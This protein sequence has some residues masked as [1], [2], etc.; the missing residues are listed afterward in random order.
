MTC[1]FCDATP[2]HMVDP[3]DKGA[4]FAFIDRMRSKL[5]DLGLTDGANLHAGPGWASF[6]CAG[7]LP[8]AVLT[9]LGGYEF[10][11]GAEGGCVT[12]RVTGEYRGP[13]ARR[14]ARERRE[15]E[16]W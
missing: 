6:A 8:P 4:A 10:R 1:E 3:F 5:S 15:R 13:K 2:G 16:N 7:E 12:V 9:N 11:I 14:L